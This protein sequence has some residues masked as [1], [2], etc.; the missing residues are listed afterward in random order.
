MQVFHGYTYLLEL[1]HFHLGIVADRVVFGA[2][3]GSRGR[4]RGSGEEGHED[5]E[6]GDDLH[7]V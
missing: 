3:L 1:A 4:D 6:L 7:R 2:L 5:E